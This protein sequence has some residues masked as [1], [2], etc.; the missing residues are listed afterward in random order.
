MVLAAV[1]DTAYNIVLLLH[2]IT[3]I[4]AF[5]P[6]VANPLLEARAK[7]VGDE[8]VLQH[9]RNALPNSRQVHFPALILAGV[10]GGALIGMSKVEDELVWQ[11]DQTWIWLGILNWIVL[12]GVVSAVIIPAEK[13]VAAGE[14]S[15]AAK[16]AQG[17]GIATLL[18]IGQ[19]Y[20]MVFKPF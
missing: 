16:V 13:K 6:A 12:C 19:L 5:A 10:F 14:L 11:F 4:V 15:A 1:N 9:Y 8:A 20:L 3:V 18:T 17:G 2:I 7:K